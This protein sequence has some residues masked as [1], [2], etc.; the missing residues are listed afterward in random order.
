[1]PSMSYDFSQLTWNFLGAALKGLISVKVARDED[2]FTKQV[3]ASGEVAR[4]RNKNRT[5]KVT[6]TVMQTSQANDIFS[7]AQQIDEGR[8]AAGVTGSGYGAL[9]GRDPNGTTV[10][11]AATAWV[12]K[13]ADAEF[14]KELGQREWVLDCAELQM[15]IGGNPT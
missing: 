14:A 9:E 15:F 1:M 4:A 7:A 3:G 8:I 13:P 12:M 5:G 11:S 2:S 6:F 10:V